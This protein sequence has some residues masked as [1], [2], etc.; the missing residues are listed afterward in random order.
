MVSN[1]VILYYIDGHN[2][3]QHVANFQRKLVRSEKNRL[4]VTRFEN[5]S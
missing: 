5:F 3:K 4:K 2:E 1:T